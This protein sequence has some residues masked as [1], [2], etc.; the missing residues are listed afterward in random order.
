MGSQWQ[1]TKEEYDKLLCYIGCGNFPE[2]DIMIFGNEEGTGGFSVEANVKARCQKYGK[3]EFD[4]YI[5]TLEEND[6]T[7][8]YWEPCSKSGAEKIIQY[9]DE[10]GIEYSEK[11]YTKGS[12]LSTISRI[13]L[14]LNEENGDID[15]WFKLYRDN[16]DTKVKIKN[17]IEQSLFK[18]SDGIQTCLVDWRPLPR[19]NERWWGTEYK[20]ILFGHEKNPYL[21][22]FNTFKGTNKEHQFSNFLEDVEKRKEI[23]KNAISKF[24][25]P[26]VIGLGG[27]KFKK[28]VFSKIFSDIKF[29]ELNRL[30]DY[31]NNQKAFKAEVQ[32]PNKKL[33]LFLL[34]F[35]VSG[36]VFKDGVQMQRCFKEFTQY[37]LKPILENN[38]SKKGDLMMNIIE[39]R[40][41]IEKYE[42]LLE[43]TLKNHVGTITLENALVNVA[44]GT[45][46]TNILEVQDAGFWFTR[47][48]HEEDEKW[49]NSFGLISNGQHTELCEVNVPLEGINSYMGGTFIKNGNKVYLVHKGAN[50][51]GMKKDYVHANYQGETLE[52][53]KNDIRLVVGEITSADLPDQIGNFLKEIQRLKEAQV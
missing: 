26:I 25:V 29:T 35:P 47:R 2:A 43:E 24:P 5:Y 52:I 32:L 31:L 33:S 44:F 14:A 11:A 1:I 45:G 19:P 22:A 23:L 53:T 37:Y 49:W 20:N 10:H 16:K 39:D 4:E 9:L 42:I 18:K 27:V 30:T 13:C 46:T 3:N 8:G 38:N 15:Y 28:T 7:K 40:Q 17:Y 36:N 41:E 48:K 21:K 6:W 50:I 51:A 12:F 34:P